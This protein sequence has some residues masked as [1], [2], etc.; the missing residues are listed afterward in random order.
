MSVP[1]VP[2]FSAGLLAN[3]L[4]KMYDTPQAFLND[5]SVINRLFKTDQKVVKS[6]QCFPQ[7]PERAFVFL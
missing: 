5:F 6:L 4:A 2:H 1:P 3:T 7:E